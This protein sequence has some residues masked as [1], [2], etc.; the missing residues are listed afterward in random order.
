MCLV[1]V[2][3]MRV[4]SV[5]SLLSMTHNGVRHS[6]KLKRRNIQLRCASHDIAIEPTSVAQWPIPKTWGNISVIQGTNV[7]TNKHTN[8]IARYL[9][10][11]R[12][13]CSI[14][15]PPTAQAV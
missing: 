6:T 3:I 4:A 8:I 15:T 10:L 9:R 5:L 2:A 12:L 14:E 7:I 11:G 13:A 1:R